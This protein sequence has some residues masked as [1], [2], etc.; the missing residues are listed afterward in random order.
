[1][2]VLAPLASSSPL[3]TARDPSANSVVIDVS[4]QLTAEQL[5]VVEAVL[6][7]AGVSVR[8]TT[9]GAWSN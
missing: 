9:D 1:L 3:S 5:L 8:V 7:A 2:K 6:S 4:D